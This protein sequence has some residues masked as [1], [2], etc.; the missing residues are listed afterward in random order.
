MEVCGDGQPWS[1]SMRW[2]HGRGVM[3]LDL[4]LPRK[5]GVQV[6]QEMQGRCVMVRI[7]LVLTGRNG[8]ADRVKCL[9]PGVADRSVC[10]KPN[11][12]SAGVDGQVPCAAAAARCSL[13]MRRCGWGRLR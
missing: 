8:L 5:D 12:Q 3:V 4:S 10:C 7:V 6:L 11:F 13:R 9:R 1:G 2:L